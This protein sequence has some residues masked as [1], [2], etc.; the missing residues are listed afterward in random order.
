MKTPPEGF[1]IQAHCRSLALQQMEM[2]T[3]IA[4]IS[5]QLVRGEGARALDAQ[6]QVRAAA[7][8]T[9]EAAA[10]RAE[11]REAGL[12]FTRFSRTVHQSLAQR[13][14]AADK[15]CAQDRAETPDR[16]AARKA[17]R[18][19]HRDEVQDTLQDMICEEIEDEGRFNA[20][21][22]DLEERVDGLYEDQDVQVEDRPVGSVMA[23]VACGLGLSETWQRW[24]GEE[25]PATPRPRRPAGSPAE[26]QAIRA[27]R[28]K[29]VTAAVE[30]DFAECADPAWI[31]GLRAGLAVRLQEADAVEML[32]TET[33]ATAAHRLCR[34]L[35]LSPMV[36]GFKPKAL[37]APDAPDTG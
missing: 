29:A 11:A 20:L 12:A 21:K 7:P 10:A 32:D 25:W 24:R 36:Y 26:I 31:P 35:G 18:D 17:R 9:D 3:E 23:G 19:R 13:A 16:L 5:L 33:I 1:D 2:L 27:K 14:R 8:G 37:D 15:L 34:S 6:A 28:R 22:D 30:R 4:E